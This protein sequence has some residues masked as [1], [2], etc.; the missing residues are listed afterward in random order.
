VKWTSAKDGLPKDMIKYRVKVEGNKVT[1]FWVGSGSVKNM[2]RESFSIDDD[3]KGNIEPCTSPYCV[4]CSPD[5]DWKIALWGRHKLEWRSRSYT[6]IILEKEEVNWL[7][8]QLS[9]ENRF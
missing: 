9:I 5:K 3:G 8:E 4:V 2:G 7:I 6:Y 1:I